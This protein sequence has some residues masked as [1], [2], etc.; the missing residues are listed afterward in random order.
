[1]SLFKTFKTDTKKEN[2][3]IP[4]KYDSNEDG[5]VPTFL[6]ARQ[7]KSNKKF[8]K[9]MRE[10]S[11]PYKDQM[12]RGTLPEEVGEKLMRKAFVKGC[13]RGWENIQNEDGEAMPFSEEAAIDLFSQLPELFDDLQSQA[14]ELANYRAYSL[15]AEAGN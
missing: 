14:T 7:A 4:I 5:T 15:E 9:T 6:V 8:A 12:D 3:G 1:M 13:L 11:A 10:L 2:D